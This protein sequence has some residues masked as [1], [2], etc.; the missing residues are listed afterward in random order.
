[1]TGDMMEIPIADLRRK[2][3]ATFRERF[4]SEEADQ[5]ADVFLWADMSGI[6]GQGVAKMTG[7][8]PVQNIEPQHDITI[9]AQETRIIDIDDTVLRKLG[10]VPE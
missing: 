5:V 7:T 6:A 10:Y 4:S 1:M 8:E 9:E 3:V 2:V